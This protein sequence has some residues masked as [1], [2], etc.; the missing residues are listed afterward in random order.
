VFLAF[1]DPALT[2]DV[3]RGPFPRY[4]ARTITDPDR[5]LEDLAEVRRRDFAINAVQALL[6][7]AAVSVDKNER[8]PLYGQAQEKMAAD[9]PCPMPYV[10]HGL[11][12]KT[13]A[14]KGFYAEADSVPHYEYVWLDR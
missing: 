7:L 1:L 8:T 5:V 3:L 13:K 9:P 2:H 4:T 11:Y 14:L 12:G 6:D 10:Q